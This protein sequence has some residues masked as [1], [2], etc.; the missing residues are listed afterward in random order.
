[1]VIQILLEYC[2]KD[3]EFEKS[4]YVIFCIIKYCNLAATRKIVQEQVWQK[5]TEELGLPITWQVLRYLRMSLLKVKPQEI[6]IIDD[7]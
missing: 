6:L 2:Q 5:S 3:I 1:M 7:Q 4:I